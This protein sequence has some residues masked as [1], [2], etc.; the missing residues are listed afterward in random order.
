MTLEQHE[1][2]LVCRHCGQAPS[3]HNVSA[4]D[5]LVCKDKSG[6]EYKSTN[7]REVWDT[8]RQ[9]ENCD[10]RRER[11]TAKLAR[12]NKQPWAQEA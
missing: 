5:R 7:E 9:L 12:L 6:N 10:E 2:P 1:P 4:R 8:L 3:E 11:L